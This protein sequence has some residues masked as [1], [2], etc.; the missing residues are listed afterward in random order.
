MFAGDGTVIDYI[1]SSPE[2]SLSPFFM[3]WEQR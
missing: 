3:F 2:D 1:Y